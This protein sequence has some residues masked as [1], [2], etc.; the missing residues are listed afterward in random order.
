MGS[1]SSM[2]A[3]AKSGGPMKVHLLRKNGIEIIDLNRRRAIRERCLN[4]SSWS[5][6]EVSNCE[7]TNCSLYPFRAGMGK[8]NAKERNKAIRKYCLWCMNLQRSLVSKCPS[9][10]CPLFPYRINRVDRSTEIKN[11]H[12]INR[13]AVVLSSKN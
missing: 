13:I 2:A 11:M 4:C 8:Q 10:D 3:A 12:K 7:F 6:K 9:R 5:P 1:N